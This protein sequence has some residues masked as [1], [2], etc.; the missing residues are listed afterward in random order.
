MREKKR[1]RVLLWI[2]FLLMALASL[3]V[4]IFSEMGRKQE[5]ELKTEKVL[6]VGEEVIIAEKQE[7]DNKN[8]VPLAGPAETVAAPDDQPEIAMAPKPL[9]E[10]NPCIQIEQ[11]MVNFFSWLDKKK[12]I[13]N[14]GLKTDTF[15]NIKRIFKRLAAGPPTYVGEEKDPVT[16][17]RNITHFFRVLSRKDLQLII[18]IMMN[19][20][21]EIEVNLKIFYKWL[22]S[23]KECP[24]IDSPIRSPEIVYQYAGFFMNTI[25][26]RAYLYRRTPSLRLLISY[27]CILIIHETDKTGK[28]SL[29]LDIFPHIETIKQEISYYPN[30]LSQQEYIENLTRIHNYYV[31]KRQLDVYSDT[32]GS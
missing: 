30:F 24:D 20:Q 11:D 18:Q 31:Q 3:G 9:P 29:G 5:K 6:P 4:Y 7:T 26:G 1:V 13:K 2:L 10:K 32:P 12:Y 17:T 25:G 23:E 16:I 27:Y 14:L 28:N 8:E 22:I 15:S 19:E 21:D